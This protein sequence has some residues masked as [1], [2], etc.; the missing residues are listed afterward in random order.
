MV[1]KVILWLKSFSLSR[2]LSFGVNG[3]LQVACDFIVYEKNFTV[4]GL[5]PNVKVSFTRTINVSFFVAAP[6]IFLTLR[7]HNAMEHI[8]SILNSTINGD[9]EGTCKRSLRNFTMQINETICAFVEHGER[10]S[11]CFV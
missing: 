3:P 6:L 10:T 1:T 2:P 4:V 9:S 7:A 11:K 8:E 5:S